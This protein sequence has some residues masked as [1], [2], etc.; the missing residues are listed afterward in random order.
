MVMMRFEDAIE[1]A[2][3][4][5]MEEDENVII[6]GED[7][8]LLRVNLFTRFGKERVR[9]A[10]ISE[11]VFL[12]AAV[13]SAMSGLRP[14]VEIMIVDFIAVA[15][16]GILNHAAKI[17]AFSGG[18]WNVP[19]VVRTACGGGYGDAGQHEQSLWGWLAHIPGVQIVVPSTPA[20]AGALMYSSIK[21]D[22][23]TI[24]FEHKLLADSWRDYLGSGGR[25]TVSYNVPQDGVEGEVPEKW[26]KIP[27]GKLKIVKEGKDITLVS[28][29]VS[30]H[31]C[32][33]ALKELEN[34][35][36]SAE[37]LDLRTVVPLDVEGIIQSVKKTG[38]A[39]GGPER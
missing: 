2:L 38:N 34:H 8:E 17:K 23:P 11:S 15:V 31:R 10:P 32:I 28:L 20:D 1:S 18:K 35:G 19:M 33:E 22:E 30:V 5:A 39:K 14:V 25:D 36:V 26:S 7:S 9:N 29:G 37:I 4:Q 13:T 12:G 27:L 6:F 24:F 16:D 3:A 21:S